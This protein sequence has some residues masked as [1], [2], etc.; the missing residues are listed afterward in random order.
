MVGRL[1]KKITGFDPG[2]KAELD[3]A[4]E[5]AVNNNE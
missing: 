2:I 3:Q 4:V 5:E 1:V